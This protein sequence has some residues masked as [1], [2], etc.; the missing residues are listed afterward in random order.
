MTTFITGGTGKTGRRVADRLT[1][2][3]RAVRLGSRSGDVRFDWD[4]SDTWAPAV[5]GC[6]S[7]YVTFAPDLAFPGAADTVDALS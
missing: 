2:M 6:A 7:A 3:G 4:D 1:T 5:D